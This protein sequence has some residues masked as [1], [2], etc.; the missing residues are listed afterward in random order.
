MA[1][2]RVDSWIE[3]R[4]TA[5]VVRWER[6]REEER[7]EREREERERDRCVVCMTEGREVICW[8]C[9]CLAMCNPCREALA[10]QSAASTHRCPCCRRGVDG[11]SRI[12][13]P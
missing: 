4:R 1:T 10:A 7:K 8:P 2:N 5:G 6:V 13:V 11:F 12:Y 9:R 3:D